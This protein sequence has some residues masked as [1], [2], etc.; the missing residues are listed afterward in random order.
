M[1]KLSI[2][3]IIFLAIISILLGVEYL[4]DKSEIEESD[5]V[6]QSNNFQTFSIGKSQIE[7][8]LPDGYG[9]H[10]SGGYEGGYQFVVR[11]GKVV[12][13]NYLS[14]DGP[15]I[16]LRDFTPQSPGGKAYS[17]S[18][19]VD[20]V[21]AEKNEVTRPQMMTLLGNKAVKIFSEADNNPVII[22]YVRGDQLPESFRGR[23]HS[24]MINGTTYGSGREFDQKLFDAVVNSLRI[25]SE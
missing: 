3:I 21:L 11:I 7:F 14:E 23:E 20:V 2:I 12:R 24:I 13:T 8:D 22:G 16:Y 17:P 5:D 6:L 4:E 9:I 25:K 18:E 19:Y 15:I 10:T 1:K